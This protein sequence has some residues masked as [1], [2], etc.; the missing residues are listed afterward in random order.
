L[1]GL[2][3]AIAGVFRA[4]GLH[5]Q[6]DEIAAN[7]AA[8]LAKSGAPRPSPVRLHQTLRIY[9]NK[10]SGLPEALTDSLLHDEAM[11]I[12]RSLIERVEMQSTDE[13]PGRRN[14]PYRRMLLPGGAI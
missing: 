2:I 12:L 4:P 14:R 7:E 8:L 3:D 11:D 13:D 10:V 1:T 9:L 5:M 6:L